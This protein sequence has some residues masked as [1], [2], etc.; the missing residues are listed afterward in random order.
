MDGIRKLLLTFLINAF[1]VAMTAAFIPGI[2]Y[3]GGVRGLLLVTVVFA[4]VNLLIKP[5]LTLLS[6]PV[7]IAT[8]GVFTVIINA[9]MLLLVSQFVRGFSI[10]PFPFP[11]ISHGPFIIAPVMLPAWGTA[12]LGALIIGITVSFLYWL[13][14]K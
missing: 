2:S 13:T 7:E 4:G 10:L 5:V 1:A 14:K 9:S 3:T 6:M 12:I 11:G 8:I